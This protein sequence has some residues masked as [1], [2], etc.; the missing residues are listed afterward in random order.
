VELWHESTGD[1]GPVLLVH[2]GICDARMWD[3]QWSTL[4]GGRRL[5]RCDLAGFGRT[6]M[7]P[8]DAAF[9]ADVVELLDRLSLGPATLVG[10]SLGGRVVLEVAVARPD[11]VER[12]VVIAASLPDHDWSAEVREFGSAE[13]AALK[14]GDLDAAVEA[15]LRMWVDGPQR[16]PDEVDPQ[17]RAFVGEMQRRAFELQLPSIGTAEERLLAEDLDD[18]L[19]ETSAPTLV[20]VGTEDVSDMIAIAERLAAEVPGARLERIAGA[21]HLPSLERPDEFERLLAGFLG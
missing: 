4:A 12:L 6:P 1:G 3:R 20:M 14:L 8:G 17:L 18:R 9:A 7:P 11:L 10:S 2:A 21:A 5:L 16:Q 19:A 15:N 13:D